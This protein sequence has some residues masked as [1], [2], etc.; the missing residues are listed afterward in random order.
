MS[1][2]IRAARPLAHANIAPPLI[3][4]QAL[5]HTLAGQFDPV[6]A[7]FVLLFGI[8]DHLYI[9]FA[10][11]V[12]DWKAD[13]ENATYNRFSGGSRV[14][15][16][17]LLTPNQLAIAALCAVGGMVAVCMYL[18]FVERRMFMVVACSAAVGL[19]WAYSFPP[20]RL[21]YRGG[22]EWL[23]GI[24]VGI[25]LP[26]IG[27]HAQS[28]ALLGVPWLVLASGFLLGWAGNVLTSLPDTPSDRAASKRSF[29]V[30]R[31]EASARLHVLAS[32]ALAA[33]L[34]PLEAPS[35]VVA[36]CI[37]V[38]A[39]ISVLCRAVPLLRSAKSTNRPAC[40]RF[41]FFCGAAI[42]TAWLAWTILWVA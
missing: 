12:A 13:M 32:I 24:G 20:L 27:Y 23:Q 18:V 28:G 37:A 41:V 40:E 42:V 29:P 2:W 1:P 30:R 11:D 14:V 39:P 10:N 31:G 16:D 22:G 33:V 5:A 8:F 36:R 3:F 26:M 25:V 4:G 6:I 21:S 15:P 19:L 7:F 34:G 38:A 35:S 17:G 9:V